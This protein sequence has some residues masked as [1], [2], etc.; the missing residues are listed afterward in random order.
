MPDDKLTGPR[1]VKVD[2]HYLD[3]IF[4]K[5]DP[6][7]NYQPFPPGYR[8]SF[9]R[10]TAPRLYFIRTGVISVSRQPDDILIDIIT[11]PTLR[12][13]I[14]LHPESSSV[15]TLKVMLSAEIAVMDREEFYKKL[16]EFNLWENFSRHLQLSCSAAVEVIL[17]LTSPSVYDGVRFQLYELMGK[18]EQ[19]RNSIS[20]ETYIRGKLRFSRSAV[21]RVLADL[22]TGGYIVMER[23]YLK[24][25]RKIPRRY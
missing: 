5:L 18:P 11:A 8:I 25:I 20:A 2:S 7:L 13:L 12:G 17:K 21:L 3:L 23:G 16:T 19:V 6:W 22:K 24:E 10:D 9:S 15:Y 4:E 14:P 1:T